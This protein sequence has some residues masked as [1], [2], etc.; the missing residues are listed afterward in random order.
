[1]SFERA[2]EE[3]TRALA[4]EGFGVLSK[5]HDIRTPENLMS[6]AILTRSSI[7]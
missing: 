5:S 6:I 3:V 2:T 1:M 7:E 4:A